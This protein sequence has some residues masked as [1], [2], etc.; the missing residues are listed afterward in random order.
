M[1]RKLHFIVCFLFLIFSQN[2]FS[3]YKEFKLTQFG[4][5]INAINKDGQKVG[6]WVT[7]TNE[8]RGE[9]GFVEEGIYKKG[10]KDGYWR[11]YSNQG[12]LLA[13]EHYILGGKDGLQQYFSFLGDLE[14]EENWKGY[15]PD[16]PYDT[17][18]VYGTGNGEIVD[19]KIVKALPYSVKDG[20]WRYF[21]SGRLLRSEQWSVNNLVNPKAAASSRTKTP[22]V[23][24]EKL[25]KP[26]AMVEWEKKNKGKKNVIRDG[27]THL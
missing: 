16:S 8:L 1:K 4:D 21:E 27:Q 26:P 17:I 19:Y 22:Y 14:R 12:D 5:T 3:Q 10:E 2:I 24:P 7:E 6:K 23:K 9:P 11:K 13:M 15:N 20:E 18:A 25:E